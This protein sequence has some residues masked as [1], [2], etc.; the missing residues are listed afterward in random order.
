MRPAITLEVTMKKHVGRCAWLVVATFVAFSCS[1]DR[2]FGEP[3]ATGGSDSGGGAGNTGGGSGG[4]SGSGGASGASGAGAAGMAGMAG[5][6][7]A[8]GDCEPGD[9][10]PCSE[11][12]LQG[13]CADGT[14]VCTPDAVWGTCTISPAEADTCEPGNDASCNGTANEGCP[15]VGSAARSCADAGALGACAAGTQSCAQ[16]VWGACSIAPAAADTC[17]AGNDDNCNGTA[18]ESCGCLE[19]ATRSCADGGLVGKCATGTQT[20]TAAGGWGACSIGPSAEDTCDEGNNDNCTGAANEGCLCIN[21]VT[22]R[23]CGV[24]NDGTQTCTNGKTNQFSNCTG[25]VGIPTTFYRDR[26][27]DGFGSSATT[28]SCTGRPSG[29]ADQ[30]GDCCDDAPDLAQ[31]ALIFPGQPT[32]FEDAATVCNVGWNYDCSSGI[33]VSPATRGN[34]CVAGT[35]YPTCAT[36]VQTLTEANCG[37]TTAGCSCAQTSI[38]SCTSGCGGAFVIKCH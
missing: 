26:D 15:C 4:K 31:A 37:N 6:G 23:S 20:C 19:G 29:Y 11:G 12:G 17:T 36:A 22:T 18:N 7:G 38:M 30:T 1:S 14:Q 35:T 10:R 3:D 2:D 32:F 5:M 8:P 13:S 16:G 21:N 28:T 27:G 33:E 24:C 9:T 34:S 25:A